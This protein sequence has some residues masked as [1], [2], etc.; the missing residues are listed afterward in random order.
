[1]SR[2]IRKRMM[3]ILLGALVAAALVYS[4][5]PTALPVRT[6]VIQAAPLRVIIEEEGETRV[7]D[8]YVIASPVTAFIRRIPWEAGDAVE[9]GQALVQVEPPRALLLDAR[10]QQET[11]ARVQA[12]ASTL[13]R[14]REELPAAEAAARLA[15][16][17]LARTETLF[18]EDIATRQ[19]LD[20]ART[21]A[22]QAN[23]ALAAA[24]ALTATARAELAAARA[25]LQG[26]SE[27]SAG[28]PV[29]EVLRAPVTGRVLAVHRRSE[30]FVN[31]GEP[32]LEIG[33]PARLEVWTDVLSQD[34]VR[35]MPGMRV[36]FDQWGGEEPL[37]GVVKRVAPFGFTKVSALG[38][39]EQ[40]VT[41]VADLLSPFERWAHLGAGYR[42]LSRFVVWEDDAVRQVPAGAL[43]RTQEGWAAF[44]VEENRAVRKTVIVGR[45]AGLVVQVRDG[46]DE[47]DVVIVHPDGSLK[48]GM[49]VR[50]QPD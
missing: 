39:E 34:A 26:G 40:R 13:Q 4:F 22:E 49:R 35:I 30:G 15:A 9:Q 38:V 5:L 23:A 3:V 32:L 16:R 29:A 44:T 43:F 33:D 17:E 27:G 20:A 25:A 47:G 8:N 36:L 48:A 31:P 21:T 12:A 42:V 1:M 28:Q 10:T 24:H 45:R 11:R 37:D 7:R 18:S 6:A 2:P 41:V 14:T 46:L 19:M 50:A